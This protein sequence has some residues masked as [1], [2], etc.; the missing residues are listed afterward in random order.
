[1]STEPCYHY[2]DRRYEDDCGRPYVPLKRAPQPSLEQQHAWARREIE[3]RH[4]REN[5]ER[6][7]EAERRERM[8]ILEKAKVQ[9]MFK[10]VHREEE[11]ARALKSAEVKAQLAEFHAWRK[12]QAQAGRLER[13]LAA[14]EGEQNS[15]RKAQRASDGKRGQS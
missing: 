9:E 2:P 13:R 8:K 4:A 3:L 12:A 15:R 14:R 6:R 5:R 10:T 7:Q 1:M 11:A